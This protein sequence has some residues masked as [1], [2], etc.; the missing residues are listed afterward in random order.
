MLRELSAIPDYVINI[1]TRSKPVI[2]EDGLDEPIL[3]PNAEYF[4]TPQSLIEHETFDKEIDLSNTPFYPKNLDYKE[5]VSDYVLEELKLI[6]DQINKENVKEFYKYC[7]SVLPKLADNDRVYDIFAA[8]FTLFHIISNRI[9]S[10]APSKFITSPFLFNPAIIIDKSQENS[11]FKKQINTIRGYAMDLLAINGVD[12]VKT[13]LYNL[14]QKPQI[15]AEFAER[16]VSIQLMFNLSKF[17]FQIIIQA[18][19]YSMTQLQSYN[20]VD[21]KQR[22]AIN[23]ARMAVLLIINNYLLQ[24]N[25]MELLYDDDYF[26]EAFTGLL[27]E[28]PVVKFVITHL[29]RYLKLDTKVKN[30][31]LLTKVI[32]I[33]I[34]I[35]KNMNNAKV[36]GIGAYFFG[37]ISEILPIS[38]NYVQVYLPLIS[39][40]IIGLNI[41]EESP[42]SQDLI[43][44]IMSMLNNLEEHD[45]SSPEVTALQNS[46]TRVFGS[47]PSQQIFL[48]LI[49]LIAGKPL[50]NI[51]PQFSIKRAKGL[52]L[53]I[54]VFLNSGNIKT[55]FAFVAQL[56]QFSAE[57]AEQAHRGEIDQFLI[58]LIYQWRLDDGSSKEIVASAFSLLML[59]STQI[60]SVAVVRH[61]ISLLCPIEGR[62]LPYFHPITL[63]LLNNM[64]MESKRKP[65]AVLPLAPECNFDIDGLNGEDFLKGF[66]F[67]FWLLINNP[68]AHYKSQLII[69]RDNDNTTL[70]FYLAGDQ[71]VCYA[72][73]HG[74][75]WTGRP[76]IKIPLKEWCFLAVTA[77]PD[78]NRNQF[79]V[80]A[81]VNND[82]P[83]I[84]Y[85]PLVLPKPGPLKIT[86]IGGLSKD[87]T[88]V[89]NVSLLGPIGF[90]PATKLDSMISV[91][92]AG[93]AGAVPTHLK[94]FFYMVPY[95]IEKGVRL[96]NRVD[97]KIIS[98]N[99]SIRYTRIFSFTEILLNRVGIDILLPLF[100]QWDLPLKSGEPVPYLTE[101]TI[102]LLENCLSLSDD[103]QTVFADAK[104]FKI[105]SNLIVK[106]DDS[107][108]NYGLYTKFVN[109]MGVLT[110]E[111]A[112]KSL[113]HDI[114]MNIEIW[115]KA[116]A[117]DHLRIVKHWARNLCPS[118]K[119]TSMLH[120]D[121]ILAILRIYY[122]YETDPLN[123]LARYPKRCRGDK[124]SVSDCR[125]NLLAIAHLIARVKF[126]DK[127]FRLLMSYILTT[128]DLQQNIDLLYFL[129]ELIDDQGQIL[130]NNACS[131]E[132]IALL[133]YLLNLK[134]EMVVVSLVATV[135]DAHRRKLFT[136]MTIVSHL[137]I[138][139][140]QLNANF[141]TKPLLLKLVELA[142]Q[143]C[144]EIFPICSWMAV[145]IGTK[146]IRYILDN[147]KPSKKLACSMNWNQW[148]VVAFYKAEPE[149][150]RS[151]MRFLVDSCGSNLSQLIAVVDVVGLALGE[152]RENAVHD[153]ILDCGKAILN[154]SEFVDINEY[155]K[156]VKHF[157]F[158]RNNENGN[159]MLKNLYKNS[160]YAEKEK[161][162]R[163]TR[164]KQGTPPRSVHFSPKK[165]HNRKARHSLHPSTIAQFTENTE[166]YSPLLAEQ[167]LAQFNP[168][169]NLIPSMSTFKNRRVSMLN[170]GKR[171][172]QYESHIEPDKKVISM[173][174]NDLD[175]KIAQVA[176]QDFYY[177]FGLRYGKNGNWL[178]YDLAEQFIDIYTKIPEPKHSDLAMSLS[179]YLVRYE[180]PKI[181]FLLQIIPKT[182]QS[183]SGGINYI[184]H[185][186][187]QAG[188]S[189]PVQSI[190]SNFHQ[191][192]F[193]FIQA[194]PDKLASKEY[195]IGSLR[196]M[197][198]I[199]KSQTEN[200][201]KAFQIFSMI[202]DQIVIASSNSMNTISDM[203]STNIENASKLW[204]RCWQSMTVDNAPWSKSLPKASIAEIH[205]KRD[206]TLGPNYAPMMMRRNY[207]F[208]DHMAASLLR[209]KGSTENAEKALE[210]LKAKL[211]AEYAANAP[212][213]LFEVGEE[214]LEH[215]SSTESPGKPAR[216]RQYSDNECIIELPCEIIKNNGVRKATFALLTDALILTYESGKIRSINPLKISGLFERTRFHHP[217]AIEIFL[218]TGQTVFINFPNI[219][220]LPILKQFKTLTMPS[221]KLYQTVDFKS[222]FEVIN[223]TEAWTKRQVSNFD[224]LMHLNMCSGRTFNDVSQYPIIPWILSDYTSD[225]L[226]LSDPD[227]YR[228]LSKPIGAINPERLQVL[229]D[230]FDTFEGV[231]IKPY[232]YSSGYSCPLSIYLWLMRME[233]FTTLHIEIQSG[234]FDHAARLFSSVANAWKLS[235][236]HQN[237]F[238]ELIPEFFCQ[239]DFLINKNGFDLGK[240]AGETI[241]DVELPPWAATP[242]DFIYMNR[243]ALESEYVSQNLNKWID[244]VWGY[245]QTGKEAL[246]NNNIYVSQ[247]Y[248][249]VWES[250]K[251]NNGQKRAETEA[252]LCHVGQVPQKLFDTEHPSRLPEIVKHPSISKIVCTDVHIR[253]LIGSKVTFLLDGK[254][255]VTAFDGA[256]IIITAT[257][258]CA[259]I[260][261]LLVTDA[262]RT[263]SK[264]DAI[265]TSPSKQ[266]RRHNSLSKLDN[267]LSHLGVEVPT[268]ENSMSTRSV[269]NF[270][271]QIPMDVKKHVVPMSDGSFF[272]SKHAANEVFKVPNNAQQAF[273]VIRQ[274]SSITAMA[275]DEGCLLTANGDSVI[276]IYMK[277]EDQDG[278]FTIPSYS[279]TIK[280]A[281]ISARYHMCVCGTRDG[282]ILFC[283]LNNRSITRIVSLGERRP[284]H[285]LITKGWG[286]VL[287]H[288]T[289][290]SSGTLKHYLT[291]FSVSGDKIR[292]TEM[293]AGI[294]RWSTTVD[295]K[296]FDHVTIASDLGLIFLFEAFYPDMRLPL[297]AFDEPIDSVEYLESERIVVAV[298]ENGKVV[299]I[300]GFD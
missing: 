87:S 253:N 36:A 269:R 169:Q 105:I 239:P 110:S 111:T 152:N 165:E 121:F 137:D 236:T 56:L 227:I 255:R 20:K 47:T 142:N 168:V 143:N 231:G 292:E 200:S 264:S 299:F 217:T 245:K 64:I 140:H 250:D 266:L 191:S 10:G 156:L 16:L 53:L 97:N 207:N 98:Q 197:K 9:K 127:D 150:K 44:N 104:G 285:I 54:S 141:V 288:S 39:G 271:T 260:N 201:Q 157:I 32:D 151:L 224:Y 46:I 196:I 55:V 154:G 96:V 14:M 132:L 160:P 129:R 94:P 59:I 273:L 103:S 72:E 206:N 177:M 40:I 1:A 226:D 291:L 70:G 78:L 116:S 76:D 134:N 282:N 198:Y 286:F 147:V 68:D 194:L 195:K 287:V 93:P 102:E 189:S 214:V 205:F 184:S 254:F 257:Y 100:A 144:P 215:P 136:D 232:L 92:D 51:N 91:Y 145:N 187:A 2:I 49:Q 50:A 74:E 118:K 108:I 199:L 11:L 133:Q 117:Q 238:R 223:K 208:D 209:D 149:L 252:I 211:Q 202:S 139:L 243:K 114:L 23:E 81:V 41:I 263:R 212:A 99:S 192:A 95:E 237:D 275:S 181:E 13:I 240:Y 274:R 69:A 174:P 281:A 179:A 204:T 235:T 113:F 267:T 246:K 279:S 148:F 221:L 122:W 298:T 19:M 219:K 146:A 233:P 63:K 218:V 24:K 57:N 280:C 73:K 164:S 272:I 12:D 175:K 58:D 265:R 61:F 25:L 182:E 7:D 176:D 48:R 112:Q 17:A 22:K 185:H 178:D 277:G 119:F 295:S 203:I 77:T 289:D 60:C 28:F 130:Q 123:A 138:I 29:R 42:Y 284:A 153:I 124:L 172:F 35:S 244:L 170:I 256:G 30:D 278:S 183:L 126:S 276:T 294:Q 18:L 258:D 38:E 8:F 242:Y 155:A 290:L 84:L 27:Y 158:F 65:T 86:R 216:D 26:I 101:T 4:E 293:N 52:K 6:S 241:N 173:M 163:K 15:Y 297:I 249:D 230:K 120:F 34:Y 89:R 128:G 67:T 268:N 161:S 31:R 283:S 71:F 159:Q 5:I 247:M 107:H 131:V 234:K 261:K 251:M 62:Y 43:L 3:L 270:T 222:Y 296:G 135:I 220:S 79:V 262:S 115:I 210:E 300:P 162:P 106:N 85:F 21:E 45:L 259:T 109:L 186:A 248:P 213:Q 37:L 171:K 88:M 188:V 190:S 66:T 82:E 166:N 228:D 90:F 225:S 33:S 83:K 193:D 75:G 229:L 167:A 125:R 180:N 80:S